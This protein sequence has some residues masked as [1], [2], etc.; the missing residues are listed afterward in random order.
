MVQCQRNPACQGKPKIKK[1]KIE[2]YNILTQEPIMRIDSEFI[3]M[4]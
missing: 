3:K 2:I 1:Q 4:K